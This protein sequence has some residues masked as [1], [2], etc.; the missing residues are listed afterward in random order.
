MSKPTPIP[1]HPTP[2]Q[3]LT[4]AEMAAAIASHRVRYPHLSL[5]PLVGNT[6]F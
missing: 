5:N 1:F 2:P 3:T 6:L 4:M